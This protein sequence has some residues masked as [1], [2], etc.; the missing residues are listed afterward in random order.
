[1]KCEG[2]S[3]LH[4]HVYGPRTF[5]C[6]RLTLSGFTRWQIG[7]RETGWPWIGG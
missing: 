4:V 7:E 5:P 2:K 3:S 1:M 6:C